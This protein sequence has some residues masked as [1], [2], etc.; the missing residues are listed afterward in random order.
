MTPWDLLI[1]NC[2]FQFFY[3]S[4]NVLI[5][6]LQTWL[7]GL[8]AG[9]LK[10]ALSPAVYPV[11]GPSIFVKCQLFPSFQRQFLGKLFVTNP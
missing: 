7:H 8:C 6:L 5:A 1:Q 9:L 3:L 4:F 2:I 11:T 10:L